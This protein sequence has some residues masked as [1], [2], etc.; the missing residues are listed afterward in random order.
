MQLIMKFLS[1][2]MIIFFISGCS[3]SMY[4]AMQTSEEEQQIKESSELVVGNI[5]KINAMLF[6]DTWTK[7]NDHVL[8]PLLDRT[9][10]TIALTID[11]PFSLVG[12]VITSP[13]QLYRY[14]W[15]KQNE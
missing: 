9:L 13:W 2:L 11:L 5:L 7:V 3:S 12:D 15:S 8:P 1:L 10:N 6:K 4:I 14:D